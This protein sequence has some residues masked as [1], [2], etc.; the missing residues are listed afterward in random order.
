MPNN[1]YEKLLEPYHIGSVKTRNRIIKS[2]AGLQY[3]VQGDNPVTKKALYFFD[4]LARGGVGLIIMES[5]SMEQGGKSFRLDND[6]HIS[7]MSEITG[8][9][10]QTRLSRFRAAR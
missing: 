10:H 7:A 9:I 4:A 8:V 2:A 3:W 1:R 5:P 6:K